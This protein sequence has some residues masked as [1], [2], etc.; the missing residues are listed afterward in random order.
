MDV[1]GSKTLQVSNLKKFSDEL[2][3]VLGD[4][5]LYMLTQS[6]EISLENAYTPEECAQLGKDI[7]HFWVL[8]K[9]SDHDVEEFQIRFGLDPDLQGIIDLF[10][11]HPVFMY[12]FGNR[13]RVG[14]VREHIEYVRKAYSPAV[15]KMSDLDNDNNEDELYS[16]P[17]WNTSDLQPLKPLKHGASAETKG[18]SYGTVRSVAEIYKCNE[19]GI[20]EYPSAMFPI[21]EIYSIQSVVPCSSFRISVSISGVI[22]T[23]TV[24]KRKALVFKYGLLPM[25]YLSRY[26]DVTIELFDDSG[27]EIKDPA[28]LIVGY[29]HTDE[30]LKFLIQ[31]HTARM[32]DPSDFGFK[33]LLH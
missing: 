3:G 9:W 11:S 8:R 13:S 28:V 31:K 24:K 4:E 12:V 32:S 23:R 29:I 15:S 10:K 22:W 16:K 30:S 7:R 18:I 25:A 6:I 14:E 27:E 20:I 2:E 33:P 26:P 19:E 21:H 1:L 5:Q 17:M